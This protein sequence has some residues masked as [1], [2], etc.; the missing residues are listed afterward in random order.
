MHHKVLS[1]HGQQLMFSSTSHVW[2]GFDWSLV[3]RY[4]WLNFLS[5]PLAT[6]VY[7]TCALYWKKFDNYSAQAWRLYT[8]HT[9]AEVLDLTGP[10]Q[11]RINCTTLQLQIT[12]KEEEKRK[13]FKAYKIYPRQNQGI[14]Y[15]FSFSW[16]V[17]LNR[18]YWDPLLAIW[19]PPLHS[20][21]LSQ[22]S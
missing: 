5:I 12:L 7:L 11:R 18:K 1:D 20:F 9:Y 6:T 8:K 21:C 22:K 15:Y 19:Y 3:F 16:H 4:S 10:S 2:L 17:S 13:L 14:G